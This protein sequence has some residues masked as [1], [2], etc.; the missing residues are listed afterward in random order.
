MKILCAYVPSATSEAALEYTLREAK[1]RGASVLVLASEEG[2]DPAKARA[3]ADTRPLVERLAESGV[4]HDLRVVHRRDDPADDILAAAE[5]GDV[6]MVVLGIRRRTPIGK[7]LLG[8][9][10]QRVIMEAPCPVVCVKPDGF[11]PPRL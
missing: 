2:L 7:I 3:V 4:P 5:S 9:T 1:Q 10:S 8:S 6:D 11:V